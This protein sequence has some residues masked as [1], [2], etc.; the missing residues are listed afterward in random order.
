[1][2]RSRLA[3]TQEA[4]AGPI[5]LD[6][7]NTIELNEGG[8]LTARGSRAVTSSFVAA[9]RN[10][11]IYLNIHTALNPGGEIRGQVTLAD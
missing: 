5:V 7:T 4:V 2:D 1:M 3:G 9:L 10:G 6:V 8:M 11:R